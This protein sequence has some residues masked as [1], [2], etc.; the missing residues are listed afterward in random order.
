MAGR[1]PPGGG[2]GFAGAWP[3]TGTSWRCWRWPLRRLGWV[4]GRLPRITQPLENL[5]ELWARGQL[6][7][8]MPLAANPLL[9]FG[10]PWSDIASPPCPR[11][12]VGV[13]QRAQVG[14]VVRAAVADGD[15]VVNLKRSVVRW[16]QDAASVSLEDCVRGCLT[17]PSAGATSLLVLGRARDAARAA[18]DERVACETAAHAGTPP[19]GR[20][21]SS[22][23][24]RSAGTASSL[25]EKAPAPFGNGARRRSN[26]VRVSRSIL[27]HLLAVRRPG[28]PS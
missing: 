10:L 21:T 26:A 24:G 3:L 28:H 22:S 9:V 4:S 18:S 12:V 11:H 25:S 6:A 15:H 1:S 17:L 14:R 5:A 23:L 2:G 7:G 19:G 13:A 16:W 27:P 8:A 20:W